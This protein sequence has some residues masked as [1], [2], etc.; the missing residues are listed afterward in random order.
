MNSGIYAI[1]GPKGKTYVGQTIR[2]SIRKQEHFKALWRE[3]HR[4]KHLQAAYNKYGK[5]AFKF[6]IL[7]RCLPELLVEREQFHMNNNKP[8]YNHAP[9]AGTNRGIK[10]TPEVIEAMRR[11]QIGYV[12]SEETKHLL[13]LAL[14]GRK[15]PQSEIDN[16]RAVIAKPV[17]LSDG[18]SWPTQ[19]EFAQ[20]C[21]YVHHAAVRNALARGHTP[22]QIARRRGLL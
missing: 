14:S 19:A 11:R 9:A 16:R 4:C 2:L 5:A 7:E 3:N 22:D 15:Q 6:E 10:R 1:R 21:G 20:A 13:S 18:R 17:K 8:L 12:T